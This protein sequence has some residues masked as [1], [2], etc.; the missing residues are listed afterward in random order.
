MK[1]P[2]IIANIFLGIG[3]FYIFKELLKN[4]EKSKLA[5]IALCSVLFNPIFIY[6]SA[7]WGQ[8]DVIPVA[9]TVWSF[10][11]LLKK[12]YQSSIFLLSIALLTKQTIVVV[13]PFYFL[14]F[15]KDFTLKKL[16]NSFLIF[17]ATFVAA[18]WP[19]QK[20]IID[21][22][23]PFV[24]FWR[25]ATNFSDNKV[26]IHAYNLWYIIA[27]NGMRDDRAFLFGMTPRLFSGILL[28][29]GLAVII[30]KF[31]NRQKDFVKIIT[32][33]SIF[34]LYTF[35]FMTGLHDRY[36]VTIL[37]FFLFGTLL[38][39]N[40]YWVFIFESFYIMI[41][42]YASWSIPRIGNLPDLVNN[43]SIIFPLIVVQI[44]LLG[45]LMFRN[46]QKKSK[47]LI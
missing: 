4:N 36:L 11:F 7:L 14:F 26:Q 15:L 41:N 29:I 34:G 28:L 30:L 35:V 16:I 3:V 12:S 37:P 21:K 9:I 33:F 20:T 42:I 2:N 47:E 6:I 31:W 1:I 13:L 17:Y 25:I 5:M 45:F 39:I 24:S 23:F 44:L 22:I 10:Y 19:F 27:Q 46:Y 32:A 18:F 43:N 8:I 40:F 38:D